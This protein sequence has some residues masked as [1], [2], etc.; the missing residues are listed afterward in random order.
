MDVLVSDEDLL[1]R[2]FR[3]KQEAS[4]A[5]MM[6]DIDDSQED[7]EEVEGCVFVDVM[8]TSVPKPFDTIVVRENKLH[9]G[10]V[11]DDGAPEDCMLGKRRG[12]KR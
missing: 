7:E 3:P 2:G 4:G 9:T 10:V 12:C 11:D 8:K 5:H 1:R 6:A